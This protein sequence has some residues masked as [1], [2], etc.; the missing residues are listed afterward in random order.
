MG[1]RPRKAAIE[2][3]QAQGGHSVYF[4]RPSTCAHDTGTRCR[5]L[6]VLFGGVEAERKVSRASLFALLTTGGA[7]DAERIRDVLDRSY[8]PWQD[9]PEPVRWLRDREE[10]TCRRTARAVVR[11]HWR[12]VEALTRALLTRGTLGSR[13]IF[14]IA[15]RSSRSLATEFCRARR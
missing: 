8:G 11:R 3:G 1:W 7:A 10:E 6:S 2:D 12:A 14:T 4:S 15:I 9:A 5:R 13:A